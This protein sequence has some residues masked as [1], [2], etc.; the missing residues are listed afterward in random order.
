[1]EENSKLPFFS[2][3]VLT[4]GYAKNFHFAAIKKDGLKGV[5]HDYTARKCIN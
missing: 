2:V 4:D 3:N 5:D 1:M